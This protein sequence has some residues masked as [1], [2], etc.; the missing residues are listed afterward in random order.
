MAKKKKEVRST[1]EAER[2]FQETDTGQS[3]ESENIVPLLPEDFTARM[4]KMLTEDE[5]D[6]FLLS[7]GKKR[8]FSLRV[9]PLKVSRETF[10]VLTEDFERQEDSGSAGSAEPFSQGITSPGSLK[11]SSS[12]GIPS[13][14]AEST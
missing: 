11:Y 12:P 1:K 9:N 10:E 4:R 3:R 2:D 13:W 5:Y 14:V 6:E 7:Y 8:R